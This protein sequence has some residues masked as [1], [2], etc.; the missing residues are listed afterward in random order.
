MARADSIRQL[1]AS[2][3]TTYGRLR[4][5]STLLREIGSVRNEVSIVKALLAEP[6]GTVGRVRADSA[7]MRQLGLVEREFSALKRDITRDPLRFISF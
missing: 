3:A 1:L 2:N 4:R 6:Q 5:D 7:I